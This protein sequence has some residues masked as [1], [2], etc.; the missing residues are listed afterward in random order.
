[1]GRYEVH[2]EIGRGGMGVVLRA[3]DPDLNRDLALKVLRADRLDRPDAAQRFLEEAQIGAQLQ[4][5]NIVPI[6]EVSRIEDGRPYFTMELVRG[7]TLTDLLKDR[8]SPADDLSRFLT[9]FE[10]VCQAVAYAH[11][12]RVIHRDLK[13][14]NVMVGAFGEVS[15]MD[16]GLAK[17]LPGPEARPGAEAEAVRTVRSQTR[18][19]RSR[20]GAVLGTPDYMAPEQ[21]RGLTERID[22][23]ADVFGLGA[24][25]CEILTGKPPYTAA[26]GWEV[27]QKALCADLS[28]AFARLDG[29]GADRELTALARVCLAADPQG[30]PG[31]GGAVAARVAAYQAGVQQRLQAAERDRAAAHARA[32]EAAAKARAERRARRLTAALAAVGLL[33]LLLAVFWLRQQQQDGLERERREREADLERA[34]QLGRQGRLD[35]ALA[36]AEQARSRMGESATPDWRARAARVLDELEQDRRDR[37]LTERLDRIRLG[38]GASRWGGPA[39]AEQAARDYRKAFQAEGLDLE[40]ADP[41]G[42][43]EKI[44]TRSEGVAARLAAALDDWAL[45]LPRRRAADKERLRRVAGLADDDPWR[46][47][48]REASRLE[49]EEQT[50]PWGLAD[51]RRQ[52]SGQSVR[53]LAREAEKAD[54]PPATL[55][56]L[57]D[58]LDQAGARAAA[59]AALLRAQKRRPGDFWI[60]CRLAEL[61][62][63]DAPPRLREAVRWYSSA[64]VARPGDASLLNNLGLVL[65]DLGRPDEAVPALREAVRLRPEMALARSRLGLALHRLGDWD[66]AAVQLREA[67]KREPGLAAAHNNLGLALLE[68]NELDQ[69]E[70]ELGEAVRLQPDLAAAHFSLGLLR[71]RQ[72]R[73][74]DAVAEL[75]QAVRLQHD[76]AEAHYQ[77][78]LAL[79]RLGELGEAVA[80]LRLAAR[81]RPSDAAAHCQLGL[82]LQRQGDIRDAYAVLWHGHELGRQTPGWSEPSARWL[83]EAERL[84]DLDGLLPRYLRGE[85][86]PADARERLELA[87]LCRLKRRFVAAARFYS[88]ALADAPRADPPK[89]RRGDG[90][91]AVLGDAA[92]GD[93][94]EDDD[95]YLAACAAALAAD[96]KKGDSAGLYDRERAALRGQALAWLREDLK[97]WKARLPGGKEAERKLVQAALQQW[98]RDADLASVRDPAA[99]D[100]LP[101]PERKE[102]EDF[103]AEVK[104]LLPR[105]DG[106]N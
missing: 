20:D 86:R 28:E 91:E 84:V 13:P 88:E 38:R 1:V 49:E 55:L 37:D 79:S 102:W 41:K 92:R 16:W 101:A 96:G 33:L 54:L 58:V 66:E 57:A 80:A 90:P 76:Y 64:L 48:L 23:R 7:R 75:R 56:L 10:Q 18:E 81:L 11:S 39:D 6:Y 17:V 22:Q 70:T 32:Q 77:L 29:C 35:E 45:A 21:A 36:L 42:Q 59:E 97:A 47:R 53:A 25:L 31:D 4:H 100:E 98:G 103:W 2:G 52:V 83:R 65:L 73:L 72:D 12:R 40:A 85:L 71:A 26:Q 78:G 19:A 50:E 104:R 68:R 62:A 94:L 51:R 106:A 44:R 95:R 99:L 43:A 105:A 46:A 69:A 27:Y 67:V 5:P 15:V 3:R 89:E 30:R 87:R 24:V 9:I 63:D 60:N 82:A 93:P 34:E 8:P 61:C 74:A 14:A